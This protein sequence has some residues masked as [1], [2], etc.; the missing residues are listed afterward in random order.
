MND[1]ASHLKLALIGSEGMLA[2]AVKQA[3]GDAWSILP[4]DLPGFDLTDRAQVLRIM[5]EAQPDVIINCAAYTNVDRC[6]TEEALATRVNGEGVGYLAE[7]AQKTGAT[8]VHISTDYVFAGSKRT[9]YVETDPTGPVSAYGRSKLAGEQAILA[10]GLQKSFIIRTSWLYGPNGNNFVETILRLAA[11]REELGI[12]ADQVGSPT[13]TGDLAEA[14]FALLDKVKSSSLQPSPARGEDVA[15]AS[16][17]YG[18]YHFSNLGQCSWFEFAGEIVTQARSLGM[19]LKVKNIK[20]ITTADYPLPATR[21]AYS[22]F[23]KTKY[24]QATGAEIPEW[25]ESLAEYFKVRTFGR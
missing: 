8:L 18:I 3:A 5:D 22:V 12:V 9:P 13:Y 19:E 7:A 2:T 11:E 21:P 4:L 6:E 14:V 23:D 24:L 17:P 20:P 1:R 15:S 25:Q 16:S 10:S